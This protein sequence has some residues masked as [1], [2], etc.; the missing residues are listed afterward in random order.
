LADDA[1]RI[2][3]EQQLNGAGDVGGVNLLAAAWSLD[4]FAANHL[5]DE[6]EPSALFWWTIQTI[7][8]GWPQGADRPSLSEAITVDKRVEGG[9][10][11]TVMAGGP[12]RVGFVERPIVENHVM[13]GASRNEDESRNA[14]CKGRVEEPQRTGEVDAEEGLGPVTNL[15]SGA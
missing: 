10:V 2:D 11:R 7:D 13:D 15:V 14:A 4:A 12:E 3:L 6:I 9:L 5:A 8:A 1:F